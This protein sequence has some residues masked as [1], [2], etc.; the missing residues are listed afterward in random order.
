MLP[1]LHIPATLTLAA[2]V[3]NLLALANTRLDRNRAAGGGEPSATTARD[4]DTVTACIAGTSLCAVAL[5]GW[6]R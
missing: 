5:A 3:F 1:R 4:L 2:T 6:L